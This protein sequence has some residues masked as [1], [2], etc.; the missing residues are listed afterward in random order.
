[1]LKHEAKELAEK[2]NIPLDQDFYILD[3]AV[4]SRILDAAGSNGIRWQ[5]LALMELS[6]RCRKI[7]FIVS[8]MNM[9]L[10]I[11]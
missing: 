10:E 7:A 2:F 3:S 4:V 5:H 11:W 1:M 9:I 8:V 6:E